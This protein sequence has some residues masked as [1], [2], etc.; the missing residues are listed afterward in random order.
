MSLIVP[1]IHLPVFSRS[2]WEHGNRSRVDAERVWLI[3]ADQAATLA[4]M[5]ARVLG[6]LTGRRPSRCECRGW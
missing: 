1:E 6:F 2:S 4:V 3:L 5:E